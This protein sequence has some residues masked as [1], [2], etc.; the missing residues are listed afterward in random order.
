VWDL[1][2]KHVKPI[3][4]DSQGHDAAVTSLS[5]QGGNYLI[6]ADGKGVVENLAH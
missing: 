5:D 6:S 4:I 3:K 2:Q 1:S